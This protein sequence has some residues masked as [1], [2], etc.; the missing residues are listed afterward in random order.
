MTPKRGNKNEWHYK[1]LESDL[2]NNKTEKI[3]AKDCPTGYTIVDSRCVKCKDQCPK[4]CLGG[5]VDSIDSAQVFSGCTIINGAIVIQIDGGSNI[6]IE[7]EN[8]LGAIEQVTYYIKIVRSY[9]ILS[10]HFFKNLKVIHGRGPGG[11]HTEEIKNYSLIVV[12]NPNL[13]EL[14]LPKVSKRLRMKR[15]KAKFHY[16]RKLCYSKIKDFLTDVDLVN[17]TTKNDVNPDSNGD[18]IPCEVT[19]LNLQVEKISAKEAILRWDKF[20]LADERMLFSYVVYY[21]KV[22]SKSVD[23]FQGRDA[24]SQSVWK[25]FEKEPDKEKDPDYM[26][27][28]MYNLTPWTLYAT[29]IQ[30]FTV[31]SAPKSAISNIVYFRTK[32]DKPSRPT[33]LK[34]LAKDKGEL[35]VRWNPPDEPNGN[36]THY[37]VYWKLQALAH[38]D[39]DQ[40]DYCLEPIV[41]NSNKNKA[42]E[43]FLEE[44]EAGNKTVTNEN[45][46]CTCPKSKKEIEESKKNRLN[47]IEFENRLRDIFI[48]KVPHSKALKTVV[49]TEMDVEKLI[50]RDKKL[51]QRQQKPSVSDIE[52]G[53]RR[54]T[55]DSPKVKEKINKVLN[56]G[57]NGTLNRTI[58][59]TFNETIN[60]TKE[61]NVT[62]DTTPDFTAMQAIVYGTNIIIPNLGHF[63][64]YHITVLACLETLQNGNYLCSD[65]SGSTIGIGKTLASPTADNINETTVQVRINDTNEVIITWQSPPNPNGLIITFEVE[66][67]IINPNDIN[68]VRICLPHKKYREINGSR[69]EKVTPGNYTFKIRATSLAGNGTWTVPRYFHIKPPADEKVLMGTVIAVIMIVVILV[70][71]IIAIVVWFVA[72]SKFSKDQDM[73]TVSINP[74]Y[75]PTADVYIPDE[76]EIERDKIKFIKE[77]GQGSFGMVWE[78]I[79]KDIQPGVRGSIRVAVKI[80][81]EDANW[82][83]KMNFLK[84]ASIMKA[85]KCH[86]VVKL[87]GVVSKGQPALVIMELMANGDLKNFLRSHRPDS[88]EENRPPPPTLKE[89]LQILGEIADGMA[90]LADKKFVHRDLAARNC[91]VAEDKT[92]KI[93]DFGMTRD[94]Y[95]TDYY[96]K[97]GKGLLPVRWMAPESLQDGLFTTMS[98]VWSFGVVLW[99]LATLAAQPYQGLSNEEVLKYVSDGRIMERPEGCPDKLYELMLQCWRFRERQRPTFK[100]II[101]MLVPDLNP[102]FEQVSYF[103]SDENKPDGPEFNDIEENDLENIDIDTYDG[104]MDDQSDYNLH[105]ESTIPFIEHDLHNT[106]LNKSPSR[107]IRASTSGPC[108]CVM[109]EEM[110]D[111]PNGHRTS[112]CSSPNS[113]IGNS[114]GSKESSKSSDGSYTQ[115]N[116]MPNGHIHFRLPHTT[117]C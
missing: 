97:G 36:V 116:G 52:E 73:T 106:E 13:K 45:S 77:L 62:E 10:L 68:P 59:G 88:E 96:R 117:Q 20:T 65:A 61:E 11:N 114:D 44:E 33:N 112:N 103:F 23:I 51:R 40:R 95:M 18:S 94:I 66:Y 70:I 101:E 21:R 57:I 72:K 12:D 6:G 80:V 63:E 90:Y 35:Q 89:I 53:K 49:D 58:N 32:P 25:N 5:I 43:R 78:G 56:R 113:A 109:L 98:D 29:Y 54:Y 42:K 111:L 82:Y 67:K 39:F 115:R 60:G 4:E 99:E 15:G 37:L 27:G 8:S 79:A 24:C 93:G 47:Q 105:D 110:G 92:V 3:C 41:G 1:T 46:C 75:M 74:S 108:E 69:F 87:L 7:L 19:T 102:N 30:P 48:K 16:N 76:W 34:I 22:T 28:L 9:P 91:M 83:D 31:G 14:F 50:D 81:N 2:L 55:A 38:E 100:Q 26:I 64:I 17:R 104:D 71:I 107:T 85:F 86:H 84:E